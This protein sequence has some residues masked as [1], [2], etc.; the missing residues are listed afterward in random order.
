MFPKCKQTPNWLLPMGQIRACQPNKLQSPSLVFSDFKRT[1][2]VFNSALKGIIK[3]FKYE[4][5]N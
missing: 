3:N 4:R 1:R 2:N 5:T